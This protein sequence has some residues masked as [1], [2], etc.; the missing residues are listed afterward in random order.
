MVKTHNRYLVLEV[1]PRDYLDQAL[2]KL[3]DAFKQLAGKDALGINVKVYEKYL[4]KGFAIVGVPRDLLSILR[5]AI[6]LVR[7]VDGNKVALIT[8]KVTGTLRKAR[9]VAQSMGELVISS[10]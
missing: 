5:A 9:A 1:Y 3:N 7:D 2:T 10:S 6:C 4:E 8:I